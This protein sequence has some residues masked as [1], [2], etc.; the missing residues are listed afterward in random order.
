MLIRTDLPPTAEMVVVGGNSRGIDR[1]HAALAGIR[2]VIVE[3]R[4]APATHTTAAS[5]GAFRLQFDNQESWSWSG[6][7]SR[8]STTSR[9]DRP[10]ATTTPGTPWVLW[11][12]TSPG[13]IDGSAGWSSNN[14][15]EVRPTSSCSPVTRCG[16]ASHT[17][18]PTSFRPG[19]AATTASSTRGNWRW[20]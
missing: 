1:A 6:R 11:A 16:R 13:R 5:T 17:L 4:P 9:G 12:T 7:P 18:V 14:T 3:R 8:C 2:P 19:S 20:V 15:D 10:A